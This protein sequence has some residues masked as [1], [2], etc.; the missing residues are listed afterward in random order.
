MNQENLH[1]HLHP[2]IIHFPIALF[3]SAMGFWAGGLLFKKKSLQ[4]TAVYLYVLGA[5]IAPLAVQT[6]LWE[7]E[8]LGVMHPIVE[9]HE[10]FGLLT[11]WSSL[12]S[13]PILW[14]VKR[15]KEKAFNTVFAICVLLVVGFVVITAYNG[16]R[17]VYEYAVG[18]EEDH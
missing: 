18:V 15:K 11:M 8:H 12:L 7:A 3:I 1:W 17:M 16:G 2:M 10:R 14:I 6:G 13:L 5:F 4:Q 9:I